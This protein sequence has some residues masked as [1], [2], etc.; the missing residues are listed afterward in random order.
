MFHT[1]FFNPYEN[2]LSCRI[3]FALASP[4]FHAELYGSIKEQGNVEI[5]DVSVEAF[6]CLRKYVVV[7]VCFTEN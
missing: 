7:Y 2:I 3:F 5:T 6:L 1:T 4:V